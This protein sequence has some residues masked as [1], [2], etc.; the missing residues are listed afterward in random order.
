MTIVKIKEIL[1]QEFESA[2]DKKYWEDKLEEAEQK[3]IT[4]K[5]NEIFRNKYFIYER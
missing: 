4:G 2:E 5:Q 1:T 3:E